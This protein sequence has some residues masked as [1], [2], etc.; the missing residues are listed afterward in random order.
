MKTDSLYTFLIRGL[1]AEESLDKSGRVNK[2]LNNSSL[3]ADVLKRLPFEFLDADLIAR[4]RRMATVYT[5]LTAFENSV[6]IFVSAK[7]KEVLKEK[8]WE[9]G[10]SVATRKKAE[11]RK[12]EEDKIKWHA[13]RGDDLFNYLD[14]GDLEKIIK[15]NWTLFEP[16]VGTQEWVNSILIP[17]EL[18]RNVIMH[19]GELSIHDIER[20]GTLIRDWISQVGA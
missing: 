13:Q 7:L 16:H 12:Q 14:F 6:R 5:A 4:A 17:L 19:S 2:L 15:S 18:S 10:V 20:I 3:D 8:W 1:L 11:S 9:D